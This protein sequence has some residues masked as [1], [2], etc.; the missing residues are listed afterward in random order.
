MAFMLFQACKR[1]SKVLDKL[2]SLN[3]K[4]IEKY[5]K[6]KDDKNETIQKIISRLLKDEDC[7]FKVSIEQAFTILRELNIKK[8]DFEKIYL[9]LTK[10]KN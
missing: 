7:F 9:Q 3:Q 6:E 5:H 10:P 4:L 1:R 2:R 8:E